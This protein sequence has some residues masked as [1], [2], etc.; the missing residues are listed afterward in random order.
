ME[1]RKVKARKT[2]I[3]LV[4]AC[5]IIAAGTAATAVPWPGVFYPWSTANTAAVSGGSWLAPTDGDDHLWADVGGNLRSAGSWHENC[6]RLVT[7]IV[8]LDWT[9]SYDVYADYYTVYKGSNC[10]IQAGLSEESMITYGSALS[11]GWVPG[12]LDL[13]GGNCAAKLGTVAGVTSISVY[14]DDGDYTFGEGT[15]YA[16]VSLVGTL[17][18]NGTVTGTVT[19]SGY[20]QPLST[21]PLIVEFKSGGVVNRSFA[22]KPNDSGVF[23]S[24]AP[25]GT[26][27]VTVKG[28]NT[29]R[30]VVPG[31]SI[32][33]WTPVDVGVINLKVGDLD[34]D[35]YIGTMDYSTVSTN[36]DTTGD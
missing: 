35:N 29:L 5:C 25:I 16:G 27:D 7:T 9:Y 23:R 17:G 12:T 21:M 31:V 32:A 30:K 2:M 20:N 34:G 36:F 18:N 11:S 13:E 8:G 33:S 28:G 3:I 4:F 6:P 10:W 14:I 24:P 26:W 1:A 15:Q 22:I 19:A